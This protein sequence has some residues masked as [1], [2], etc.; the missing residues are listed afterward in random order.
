MHF[1]PFLYLSSDHEKNK[2]LYNNLNNEFEVYNQN[3]M[4]LYEKIN[5]NK[6]L[7]DILY[8]E[9]MLQTI[10]KEVCNININIFDTTIQE[11]DVWRLREKT[12]KILSILKRE[13]TNTIHEYDNYS[14]VTVVQQEWDIDTKKDPMYWNKDIL[15]KISFYFNHIYNFSDLTEKYIL[16]NFPTEMTSQISDIKQSVQVVLKETRDYSKLVYSF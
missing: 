6:V 13:C 5:Q 7:Y 16:A 8:I 2:I 4:K 10:F 3:K 9:S 15:D 14:F 11:I 1:N 12:K